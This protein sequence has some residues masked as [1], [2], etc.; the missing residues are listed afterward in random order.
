MVYLKSAARV[1]YNRWGS[2]ML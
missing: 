2:N 1:A